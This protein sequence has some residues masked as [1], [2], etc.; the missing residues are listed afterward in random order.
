MALVSKENDIIN[1]DSLDYQSEDNKEL[2]N[3]LSDKF[4]NSIAHINDM[5]D[6]IGN[7]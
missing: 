1:I 4:I 6:L 5:G 3:T 2:I 7:E